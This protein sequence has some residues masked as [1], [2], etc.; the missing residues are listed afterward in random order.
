MKIAQVTDLHL[1]DFMTN[2]SGVNGRGNFTTILDAIEEQGIRDLVVTGDLGIP[3]SLSWLFDT[4]E[5]RGI[6][7][8]YV[9]GNHDKLEDI[10]HRP[11]ISNFI[12]PDGLYYKA[13]VGDVSCLFLDSSH[14]AISDAQLGWLDDQLENDAPNLVIFTHYPVLDCGNT[15]MDRLY[16]LK[17]RDRVTELLNNA[18]KRIYVFCG[19]YHTTHQQQQGEIYQYVT[20]SAVLQLKQYSDEIEAESKSFGYRLIDLS[21]ENIQTEVVLLKGGEDG[22]E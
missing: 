9:L 21:P 18:N 2:S 7:S 17:N 12:K 19:H 15:A 20:P 10:Q 6:K 22:R 13:A 4:I 1:D 8:L 11:E 3:N 16:P 5:E 14:A